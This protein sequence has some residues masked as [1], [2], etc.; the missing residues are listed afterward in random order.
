MRTEFDHEGTLVSFVEIDRK[1]LHEKD[2][3]D[4]IYGI[5][6]PP[7]FVLKRNHFGWKVFICMLLCM[8]GWIPGSVY[9]FWMEG[10]PIKVGF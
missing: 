8:L 2:L 7:L 9:A 1:I 5:L 6:M 4:V 10:M 3:N